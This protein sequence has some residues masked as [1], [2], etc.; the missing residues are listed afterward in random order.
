MRTLSYLC[1]LRRK[2]SNIE[3]N[4]KNDRCPLLYKSRDGSVCN[5]GVDSWIVFLTQSNFF[6]LIFKC[7]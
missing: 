7:N 4:L 1:K 5:Y 6:L 3:P 2:T